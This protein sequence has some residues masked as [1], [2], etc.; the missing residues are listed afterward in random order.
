MTG[1]FSRSR[2]TDLQIEYLIRVR[3]GKYFQEFDQVFKDRGAA[4]SERRRNR[5][6]KRYSLSSPNHPVG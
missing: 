4:R 6:I 3:E 5:Q 1:W 2:E